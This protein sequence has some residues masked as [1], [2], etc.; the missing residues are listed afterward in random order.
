VDSSQHGYYSK[1]K[2]QQRLIQWKIGAYATLL[3]LVSLAIAMIT[4]TYLIP[5]LTTWITISV[6][7]PFV[8]VP[9]LNRRGKLIYHSALFLSEPPRNGVIT[10]HGGTLFDYVFAIDRNLNGRQR[11]Q[12]ILQQYLEG[13]QHLIEKLEKE[14]R[15]DLVIRGTSYIVN[16]RT[17]QKV[18]F[19][20]VQTD[21]MQKIVLFFNY[22]NLM[23][24]MSIAKGRFSIPNLL[25]V[26]TYEARLESLSAH[27]EQIQLLSERLKSNAF[28]ENL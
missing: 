2:T 10:I 11:R 1:T 13:L 23:A 21:P 8:D 15:F 25:L 7:A 12:F 19:E 16:E 26:K 20:V 17:G 22:F 28:P 3:I 5:I 27:R 9:L 14:Q 4:N 24:S 6:I 18:G